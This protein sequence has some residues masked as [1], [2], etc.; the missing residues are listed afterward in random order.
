MGKRNDPVFVSVDNE[1][2]ALDSCDMIDIQKSVP[3]EPL[4][5]C[6]SVSAGKRGFKDQGFFPFHS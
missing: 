2:R 4:H 1:D 3:G 6:H 5:L